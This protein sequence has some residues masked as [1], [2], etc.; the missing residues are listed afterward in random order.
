MQ[1]ILTTKHQQALCCMP[2]L[3]NEAAIRMLLNNLD[4]EVAENPNEFI[5]YGGNGQAVRNRA[6]LEKIIEVLLTLDE[7]HS[8]MVQSGKPVGVVRT[9]PEAPRVLIANSNLVPEWAT[10]DHFNDLKKRGLMMYGQMTAGSWIYIGTQGILQEPMKPLLLVGRNIFKGRWK[11]ISNGWSWRYGGC[12]T[13]GGNYG[14]SYFFRVDIDPTR[15]EKRIKTRY[16][17]RMT[18]SYDEAMDWVLKAKQT[19]KIYRLDW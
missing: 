11:I 13:F 3:A 2:K 14:W 8:L 6:A 7:N 5:V 9:H 17:D 19:K 18:H 4:S 10:W 16:I 15:I 12:S 1:R